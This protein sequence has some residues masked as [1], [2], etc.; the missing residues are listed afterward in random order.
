MLFGRLGPYALCLATL[1]VSVASAGVLFE[2][3]FTDGIADGWN[4]TFGLWGVSEQVYIGAEENGNGLRSIAGD[5]SWSSYTFEARMGLELTESH[6]N[7]F[8]LI[9][10]DQGDEDI[11]FTLGA[12]DS[13]P[14][15]KITHEAYDGIHEFVGVEALATVVSEP[16]MI[17][18]KWY[19]IKLCLDDDYVSAYVDGQLVAYADNLPFTHGSIGLTAD[20][21]IAYFDDIVVTSNTCVPVPGAVFLGTIGTGLVGWLSRRRTL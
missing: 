13:S 18:G 14:T 21:P 1:F 10:Y 2:D 20:D 9:F 5:S 7:E 19:D 12:W 16:A 6:W 17:D 3:H 11:R 4:E 8:G 15:V